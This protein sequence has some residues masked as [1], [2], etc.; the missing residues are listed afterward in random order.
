MNQPDKEP[1]ALRYL[2]HATAANEAAKMILRLDERCAT[3]VEAKISIGLSLQAAELAGKGMLRALG[4]PAADIRRNHR[5]QNLLELLSAV[6]ARLEAHENGAVRLYGRFMDWRPIIDGREF[7]QTVREYFADHFARGKNAFPRNYFYPDME[8]FAGPVPIQ[9]IYIM[10]Q[11]IIE[12]ADN[13]AAA[14]PS[15][16]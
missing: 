1:T 10:V 3:A 6:E 15:G 13:V 4:T 12:C 8:T 2:E 5:N 9:A 7:R 16:R 11:K 14:N